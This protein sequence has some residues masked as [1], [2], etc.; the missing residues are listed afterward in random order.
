MTRR[1]RWIAIVTG[2]MLVAFMVP[3][4]TAQS[5]TRTYSVTI[6][7]LTE[8]QP[9]TPPLVAT[10]RAP[11]LLFGGFQPASDGLQEIAEN[12]NLDPLMTALNANPLVSDVVVA[13]A[14]D[15]PPL[16]PGQT[17]T[18]DI[19]AEPGYRFLSYA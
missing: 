18:F 15:P 5:S 4:A 16:M 13:V 2:L 9:F 1:G 11:V 8:G 3:A 17:V 7:N 19:E 14:G 6:T 10:H 12:G